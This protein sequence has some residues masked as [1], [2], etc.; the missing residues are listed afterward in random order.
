MDQYKSEHFTVSYLGFLW[1]VQS[2]AGPIVIILCLDQTAC[3]TLIWFGR[4]MRLKQKKLNHPH[5]HHHYVDLPSHWNRA[6][7]DRPGS[8]FCLQAW[9]PEVVVSG[10]WRCIYRWESQSSPL[11]TNLTWL[12]QVLFQTQPRAT[13][14]FL[15]KYS[16]HTPIEI[17]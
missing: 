3:T 14:A 13:P 16:V 12:T 17:E 5:H 6:H 8:G 1:R 4:Q 9:S 10:W 11:S 2:I 7:L 15:S